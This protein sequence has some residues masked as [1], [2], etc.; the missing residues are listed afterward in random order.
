MSW[1]M[2]Y[3]DSN[4][5]S[6]EVP[7]PM[8]V[9]RS[10][11]IPQECARRFASGLCLYC[12]TN[13]HFRDNC[14]VHLRQENGRTSTFN[15]HT[16]LQKV[17]ALSRIYD[18]AETNPTPEM[19]LPNS[20]VLAPIRVWVS[21]I[22]MKLGLPSKKVSPWYIAPFKVLPQI[23]PRQ[24]GTLQYL[25]DWEGYGPEEQLWVPRADV[26]DPLYLRTST[27]LTLIVQSLGAMVGLGLPV[28]R[29]QVL[30][31]RKQCLPE[32]VNATKA[33]SLS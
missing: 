24:N 13:G 20:C 10:C 7:E 18:K 31:V 19:I 32:K 14:P 21:T 11:V 26:L 8:Q 22:N 33:V 25:V 2:L 5:G 9:S 6:S 15:I 16:W 4:D 27:L 30:P 28:L 23:N 17:D 29:R 3:Q 1:F 12:G